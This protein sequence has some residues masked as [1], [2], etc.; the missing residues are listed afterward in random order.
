M[1]P[2]LRGFFLHTLGVCGD[3]RPLPLGA[4][5]ECEQ[6]SALSALRAGLTGSEPRGCGVAQ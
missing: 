6:G 4:G 3:E 5:Q 1:A 2:A